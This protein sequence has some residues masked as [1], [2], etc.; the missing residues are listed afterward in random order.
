MGCGL[1]ETVSTVSPSRRRSTGMAPRGVAIRVPAAKQETMSTEVVVSVV[2]EP[3]PSLT[4]RVISVTAALP[5]G[6]SSAADVNT[7][8]RK[9]AVIAA[10]VP[11]VSV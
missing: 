2:G 5:D 10:G 1:P 9:A 8:A 6:H 3:T 4:D 7:R 11:A